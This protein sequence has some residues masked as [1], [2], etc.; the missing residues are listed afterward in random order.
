MQ[1]PAHRPPTPE[2]LEHWR[3]SSLEHELFFA[4]LD[5]I[6]DHERDILSCDEY[7]FCRPAFTHYGVYSNS[8]INVGTLLLGW[9]HGI[10]IDTCRGVLGPRK[11]HY[12]CGGKAYVYRFGGL[13][14]RTGWGGFCS[15]CRGSEFFWDGTL[16][17]LRW[18]FAA[19]SNRQ[20]KDR[21][22]EVE[23]YEG[24]NFSFGPVSLVPAIKTRKVTRS[25][26]EVLSVGDLMNELISKTIR[27]ATPRDKSLLTDFLI[28]EHGE[29]EEREM[30]KVIR[31]QNA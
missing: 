26:V 5:L 4:N 25:L 1:P 22:T 12:V 24:R 9:R 29:K 11:E 20:F 10:L 8:H 17:W 7:F 23:E 21:V 3:V 31:N 6:L 30:I 19:S 27:P 18:D 16:T 15:A 13:L 28:V 14:S 2:Q